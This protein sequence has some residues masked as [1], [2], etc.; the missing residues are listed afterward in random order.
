MENLSKIIE[1]ILF[2]SGEPVSFLDISEKLEIEKSEVELAIKDLQRLK[3][4]EI[5]AIR[6]RMMPF[7][8]KLLPDY[9]VDYGYEIIKSEIPRRGEKDICV[10]DIKSV[11]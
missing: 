2:V 4:F 11:L 5:I 6:L 3:Q 7:K 10:F 1:G 9:L 8:T